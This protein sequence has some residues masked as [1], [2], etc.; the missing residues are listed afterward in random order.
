MKEKAV[1]LL[2]VPPFSSSFPGND[3]DLIQLAW[4]CFTRPH[5]TLIGLKTISWINSNRSQ[6]ILSDWSS[7]PS[8]SLAHISSFLLVKQEQAGCVKWLCN[9]N[10]F[11]VEQLYYRY[12][13]M[14]IFFGLYFHILSSPINIRNKWNLLAWLFTSWFTIWLSSISSAFIS[15]ISIVTRITPNLSVAI[16]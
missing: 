8:A 14:L 12:L 11:P 9:C 2:H 7:V 10:L 15:C 4:Q 16:I 6:R 1:A 3:K 13:F 5:Q